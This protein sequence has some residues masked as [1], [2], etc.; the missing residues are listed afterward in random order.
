MT[1]PSKILMI[2]GREFRLRW[3]LAISFFKQE[4]QRGQNGRF[5]VVVSSQHYEIIH[6]RVFN[7]GHSSYPKIECEMTPCYICLKWILLYAD[8]SDRLTLSILY[9][10]NYRLLQ[11]NFV[12]DNFMV[13]HDPLGQYGPKLDEFLSKPSK[14]PSPYRKR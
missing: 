1:Y 6:S 2:L 11:Y 12:A 10:C 7:N 14:Q 8:K 5:A 4:A 3:I 9:F 13:P